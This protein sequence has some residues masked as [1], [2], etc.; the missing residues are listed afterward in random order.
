[1]ICRRF[2]AIFFPPAEYE[3]VSFDA[4]SENETFHG[5]N[6][7]LVEQ[8]YYEVFGFPDEDENA[9]K[10]WRLCLNFVRENAILHNMK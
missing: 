2:L 6:K 9:E 7:Y 5:T 8:G 1:M 4:I 3:R 10:G